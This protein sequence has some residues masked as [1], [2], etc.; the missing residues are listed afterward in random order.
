MP[1]INFLVLFNFKT[2]NVLSEAS[3]AFTCSSGKKSSFTKIFTADPSRSSPYRA[4]VNLYEVTSAVPSN[5]YSLNSEDNL[6]SCGGSGILLQF[7]NTTH[8]RKILVYLILAIFFNFLLKL[9]KIT[10]MPIRLK[11]YRLNA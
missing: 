8:S 9:K 3:L 5:Q 1:V 11:F 4:C 10:Q 6:R 7:V 2:G